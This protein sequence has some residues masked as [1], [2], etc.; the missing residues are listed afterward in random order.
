M[1]ATDYCKIEYRRKEL[2]DQLRRVFEKYDF[3]LTPT[4]AVPPFK[5]DVGLGP[6]EIAGKPV[7]PT[8][9]TAFTFPLSE[10]YPSRTFSQWCSVPASQGSTCP[11]A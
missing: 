3:L 11:R 6:N 10:T 5:I 4:N 2:W 8:G 7:G 9:W 1:K